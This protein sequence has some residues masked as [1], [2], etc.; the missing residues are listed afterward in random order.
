MPPYG[1]LMF[2]FPLWFMDEFRWLAFLKRD[3]KA[4]SYYRRDIFPIL[5]MRKLL[6]LVNYPCD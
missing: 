1:A 5:E 4:K 6:R 3:I 2:Y